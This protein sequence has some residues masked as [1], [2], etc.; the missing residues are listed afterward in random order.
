MGHK[1]L[2]SW[3][4]PED[5]GVDALIL[6]AANDVVMA[7]TAGSVLNAGAPGQTLKTPRRVA[8]AIIQADSVWRGRLNRPLAEWVTAVANEF[9]EWR[10][11]QDEEIPRMVK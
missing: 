3:S 6:S 10:K 4:T 7:A 1:P 9:A 5:W 8:P 2:S 11:R